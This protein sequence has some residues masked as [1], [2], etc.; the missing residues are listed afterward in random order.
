MSRSFRST[1][2]VFEDPAP[3][4][5]VTPLIDVL[6]VLIVMLILTIPIMTH[7]IPID[8]PAPGPRLDPPNA[9]HRIAIAPSGALS[10]DGAA[11]RADQLPARLATVAADPDAALEIAADGT[12]RYDVFA[13]TLATIKSAGITRLGFVGNERMVAAL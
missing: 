11:I 4:L 9:V 13:H 2:A 6:L 7:K 5:N 10:W 3:T 8:L 1:A 12:A